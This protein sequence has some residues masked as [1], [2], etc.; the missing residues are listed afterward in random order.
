MDPAVVM[1]HPPKRPPLQV[2]I[3]NNKRKMEDDD[4]RTLAGRWWSTWNPGSH[5][6]QP[7]FPSTD[8][9]TH[10]QPASSG[11]FLLNFFVYISLIKPASR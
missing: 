2:E 9:W 7:S 10:P 6:Q 3:E 4:T 1:V 11:P 5:L 8:G